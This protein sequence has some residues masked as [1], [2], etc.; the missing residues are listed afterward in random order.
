M[1]VQVAGEIQDLRTD[2]GPEIFDAAARRHAKISGDEFLRRWDDGVFNDT[3][4]E[5]ILRVVMLLPL[6]RRQSSSAAVIPPRQRSRDKFYEGAAILLARASNRAALL[7]AKLQ[8]ARK[9]PR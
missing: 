9:D 2:E 6:V 1:A 7:Y 3:E 4:D 5:G 8:H